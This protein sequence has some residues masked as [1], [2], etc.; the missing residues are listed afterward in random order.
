MDKGIFFV[1]GAFYERG[2]KL[3]SIMLFQLSAV[4]DAVD[5]VKDCTECNSGPSE[6]V[7]VFFTEE[8]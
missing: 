6:P 4:D 2:Y 3:D 5:T 8:R 1:V 7:S